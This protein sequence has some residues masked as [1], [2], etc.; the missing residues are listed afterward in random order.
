MEVEIERTCALCGA[1]FKCGY[2]DEMSKAFAES[3]EICPKC[4]E[5]KL[6][7]SKRLRRG[8]R[9]RRGRTIT[10]RR[11]LK[12]IRDERKSRRK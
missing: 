8:W 4:W 7:Y 1:K 3:W 12:N 6:R 10:M 2:N 9:R 5:K 11:M